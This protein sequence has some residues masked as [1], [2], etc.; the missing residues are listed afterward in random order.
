M[1]ASSYDVIDV[2]MR[3]ITFMQHSDCLQ[4]IFGAFY[5]KSN[6]T[7]GRKYVCAFKKRTDHVTYGVSILPKISEVVRK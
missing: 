2:L 5:T 7:N 3:I 6:L 4:N 1:M